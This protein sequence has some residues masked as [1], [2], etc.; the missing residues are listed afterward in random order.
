MPYY[1]NLDE[2]TLAEPTGIEPSFRMSLAG[3]LGDVLT[4][5]ISSV[6]ADY[7]EVR[8]ANQGAKL[9]RDAA[10]QRAKAA[11]VTMTI[12]DDGYT[13][14][15][16]DIL[17]RRKQAEDMRRRVSD[18]TPWSWVGTPIRG[19]AMLTAGVLDPLNVASAFVP[20]I[21]EARAAALLGRAGSGLARA[22][23]RGAIGLAEGAVGAAVIEAPTYL[24]RQDLGDDYKLTDSLLNI[25]FGTVAGGG[26][27]SVGGAIGDALSGNRYARFAGMTTAQVRQ[28]FDFERGKLADASSFTPSMRRAVGLSPYEMVDARAVE[29]AAM[30][31]AEPARA[32]IDAATVQDAPFAK[33]TERTPETARASAVASLRDDMKAELLAEMS[34]RAEPRVVAATRSELSQLN[35]RAESLSADAE[36]KRRAKEYQQRG[37]SRKAAEAQARK[38][39]AAESADVK[40][41]SD[42]LQSTIDQNARAAQAEQDLAAIDRGEVPERFEKRVVDEAEGILGASEIARAINAGEE[43]PAAFVLGMVSPDTREAAFRT[44]VAHMA[45][46]RMPDVRAVVGMDAASI[47]ARATPDELRITADRQADPG[48]VYLGDSKAADSASARV[49]DA[50]PNHGVDEATADLAAAQRQLQALIDNLEKAGADVENLKANTSLDAFDAEVKRADSIGRAI[51]AGALCGVRQ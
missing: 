21:R 12:P 29:A 23:T 18:A 48:S 8:Q 4:G 28:V 38:D 49:K 14:Q 11:G 39:I 33:L 30:R 9:A 24:L 47:G 35:R 51:K 36:F 43:P 44:A 42:R 40:A 22:G 46:G 13:E 6:L 26:L 19:G 20:V 37:L 50:P 25:A 41:T 17:I 1:V 3:S 31:T 45:S 16:L 10:T 2:R 15:A 34:G 5:N 27:H 32:Q 7:G